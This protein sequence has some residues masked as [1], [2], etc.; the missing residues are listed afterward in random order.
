MNHRPRSGGPV[1]EKRPP[2][3]TW[4]TGQ[5]DTCSACGEARLLGGRKGIGMYLQAFL[6]KNRVC[7]HN[8]RAPALLRGQILQSHGRDAALPLASLAKTFL[9]S[10]VMAQEGAGCG[11]V[12]AM[13]GAFLASAPLLPCL[14]TYAPGL[15]GEGIGCDG[16]HMAK[17]YSSEICQREGKSN[18]MDSQAVAWPHRLSAARRETSSQ[19]PLVGCTTVTPRV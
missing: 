18:W 6:W 7:F 1:P 16:F 5:E 14:S 2:G 4:F 10:S 3:G 19:D 9:A 8:R 17:G 12:G 11:S 13:P 15:P